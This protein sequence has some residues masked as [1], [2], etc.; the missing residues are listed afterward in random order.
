MKNLFNNISQE[1]KNRILEMHSGKKGVMSENINII[2]E[3]PIPS[4]LATEFHLMAG[5]GE[6]ALKSELE[7]FMLN[8]E[9]HTVGGLVLKTADD[10]LNAYLAGK[11]ATNEV[12]LL[13]KDIINNSKNLDLRLNYI[14]KLVSSQKYKDLMSGLS[15]GEAVEKL[16]K[17]G[18]TKPEEIVH[19]YEE[20]GNTFQKYSKDELETQY[21]NKIKS[22]QNTAQLV[23]EIDDL[24]IFIGE[25]KG[26]SGLSVLQQKGM[27]KRVQEAKKML[28]KIKENTA[29][30]PKMS[31]GQLK[32]IEDAIRASDPKLWNYLQYGWG[33]FKTASPIVKFIS[34][35]ALVGVIGGTRSAKFMNFVNTFLQ[36]SIKKW[37][38]DFVAELFSNGGSSQTSTSTP[39]PDKNLS[40]YIITVGDDGKPVYTLKK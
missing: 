3:Q 15:K 4:A 35:A 14:Q 23:K 9:F 12:K 39:T 7:R 32:S 26:K 10:V 33:K 27:T 22:S 31:E 36:G 21:K 25:F 34:Y 6:K 37:Y 40:N 29:S 24:S 38:N 16:K 8:S 17:M 30:I 28:Q 2:N 18:Y 5:S 13:T 11:L 1:E 20:L 19:E